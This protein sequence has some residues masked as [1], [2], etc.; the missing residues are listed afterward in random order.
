MVVCLM[1]VLLCYWVC[2]VL[3]WGW[4]MLVFIRWMRMCVWMNW[5]CCLGCI[6]GW[7][8]GCWCEDGGC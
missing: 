1:F 5:K 4:L 7:W 8:S 3:K 2:S 6:S